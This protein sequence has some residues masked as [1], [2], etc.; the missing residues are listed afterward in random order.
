[1]TAFETDIFPTSCHF[2]CLA[3][4]D[5]DWDRGSTGYCDWSSWL[6][7]KRGRSLCQSEIHIIIMSRR[8]ILFHW[9]ESNCSSSRTH[10]QASLKYD[11][12]QASPSSPLPVNAFGWT[13]SQLG[14]SL[15]ACRFC[16]AFPGLFHWD[17]VLSLF[18]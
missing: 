14:F 3:G 17:T 6:N 1:M 4:M 16:F 7:R 2:L 11:L 10:S 15:L 8:W 18:E 5:M 13:F 12:L 9:E